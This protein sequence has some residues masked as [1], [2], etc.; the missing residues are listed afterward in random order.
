MVLQL[1]GG[2]D[3]LNT[4]IP[5]EDPIYRKSR[6]TLAITRGQ[7]LALET[8]DLTS[9]GNGPGAAELGFHPRMQ[10]LHELYKEGVVAVVQG[11]GYPNPNRS[12]FRSMDIWHTARPD[13]EKTESGWLGETI[14]GQ[15][16]G[17]EPGQRARLRALNVGEE[18]LPLALRGTVQIPTL[19]NLDWVDF[20]A[21]RRG[22]SLR[23]SLRH[24]NA[25]G[26]T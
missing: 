18:N 23:K 9:P 6:P 5:F 19:Q 25:T 20:L 24:L 12:H 1:T 15:E 13:I 17:Q 26:R 2:N 4:V 8:G 7:A 3:G 10:S 22:E 16:P 21:S 14:S 11:V